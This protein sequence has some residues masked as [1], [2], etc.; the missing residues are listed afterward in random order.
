MGYILIVK[1][2]KGTT[3]K[4]LTLTLNHDSDVEC[5]NEWDGFR[6]V[7]F[8][9]HHNSYDDPHNYIS[10]LDQYGDVVPANI[11]IKRKLKCETAFILSYFEHG[12]CVWS[13]RGE[14][15]QCQWDNVSVAGILLWEGKP[16]RQDLRREAAR[17]FCKTYTAWANGECYCYSIEDE[18]GN[19]I[20]SCGGFYDAEGMFEEIRA[21]TKGCEVEIEGP[22]TWLA[23][24]HDVAEVA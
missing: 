24:Y 12:N 19:H 13:L 20:D 22:A 15:P 3:M 2:T 14:G 6:L 10:H 18:E 4:K 21:H 1:E 9:R 17:D 5:P 23:Q 8:G 11:G 7:S 16:L